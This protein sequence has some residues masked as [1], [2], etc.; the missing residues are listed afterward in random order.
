MKKIFFGLLTIAVLSSGLALAKEPPEVTEPVSVSIS[1]PKDTLWITGGCYIVLE[2][3]K[4]VFVH[5]HKQ[6]MQ[7][8][9]A[10]WKMQKRESKDALE[11]AK[12]L[13]AKLM[14]IPEVSGVRIA[15]RTILIVIYVL[16]EIPIDDIKKVF[17]VLK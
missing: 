17:E 4:R 8:K 9:L 6:L 13:H 1:C 16:D 14:K 15:A 11:I 5:T 10:V 12:V 3:P 7:T 2:K